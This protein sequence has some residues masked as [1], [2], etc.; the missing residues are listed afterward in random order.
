MPNFNHCRFCHEKL[1]WPES[2]SCCGGCVSVGNCFFRL[3]DGACGRRILWHCKR[4]K[5]ISHVVSYV[6]DERQISEE[7]CRDCAEEVRRE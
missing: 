2:Q 6:G 4:C 7:F 5:H 1:E 3:R